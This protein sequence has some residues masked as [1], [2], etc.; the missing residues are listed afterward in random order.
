MCIQFNQLEELYKSDI[1]EFYQCSFNNCYC[2]KF[3]DM[4]F[5]LTVSDFLCF[6]KEI[7]SIDIISMLNDCSSKSDIVIVNSFRTKS[8][9]VLN[10]LE[11]IQLKELLGAAKFMIELNSM[12]HE[13]LK[14][15]LTCPVVEHRFQVN[16][17]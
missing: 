7:D 5:A 2:L 6:K 11:V 12:I 17:L 14:F 16:K 4:Q 8:F 10:A 15:P 1:G 3:R 13:C 9:L